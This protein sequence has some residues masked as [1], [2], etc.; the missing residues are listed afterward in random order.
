MS[1]EQQ[2]DAPLGPA[3]DLFSLARVVFEGLTGRL[4]PVDAAPPFS[5]SEIADGPQRR[6]LESVLNACLAV[7]AQKRPRDL[8]EVAQKLVWAAALP[9]DPGKGEALYLRL[10]TTAAGL[11]QEAVANLRNHPITIWLK[12]P[13]VV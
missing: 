13:K 1:P 3:S 5:L 12:G 9:A 8:R 10:E 7:E 2:G 6:A 4:P 11:G